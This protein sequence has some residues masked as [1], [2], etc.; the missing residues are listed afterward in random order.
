MGVPKFILTDNM[1]S[2]V[3]K[4]DLEGHPIWNS[5][6]EAFMNAV[7]FN[8]KLCKPR[9]PFTKGKV[10]RLIRYVK[11]NFLVGR[12]FQDISDLND[13]ALIWSNKHNSK[14]QKK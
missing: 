4:R 7:G 10:E 13:Q 11:D 3:N 12:V 14:Y 1:K 6:Y 5:E 9:H 2:V 8:T